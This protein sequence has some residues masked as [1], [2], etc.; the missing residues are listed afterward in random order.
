MGEKALDEETIREMRKAIDAI[1]E[2]I[3]SLVDRRNFYAGEI[4]SRRGTTYSADR[5]AELLAKSR[6]P[7]VEAA[8]LRTSKAA[9]SN[10]NAK[11]DPAKRVEPTFF[12]K[13]SFA[14]VAGPC[15]IESESHAFEC[16]EKL[17]ELGVKRMRG[18]CWKP[19][20]SPGGFQGHG[21]DALVWMRAACTK[22]GLELWTEVRDV[23]V[24]KDEAA[25]QLVDVA[26]VGARNCQNFELLR[27]VGERF[28]KAALK[29]GAGVSVD[30]WLAAAE[31]VAKGGADVCLVE[32]GVR[33]FDRSFRNTLDL[34][35]AVWAR[36]LSGRS[37]IVDPSHATGLP[38]LVS[39]M[40]RAAKAAGLDGAMVEAHPRPSESVT[41]AGQAIGF[42]ALAVCLADLG[43]IS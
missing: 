5:E 7:E 42:G 23:E 36:K 43:G 19:R 12:G 30:E 41:D 39:P 11:L 4:A 13:G 26:W 20:T 17:A 32:R 3:G 29:R 6:H 35:G 2:K 14:V 37:V 28:P 40:M 24:A 31:Y 38:Y 10:A 22:H 9:T 16:A 21:W 33:T 18:G 25:A 34:A 15:S 8:L 27:V 1:D